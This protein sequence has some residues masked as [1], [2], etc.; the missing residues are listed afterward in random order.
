MDRGVS[1]SRAASGLGRV[2]GRCE[3]ILQMGTPV[4][5]SSPLPSA[6]LLSSFMAE[7]V[8]ERT[9]ATDTDTVAPQVAIAPPP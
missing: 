6:V 9:S 4:Y 7:T 5:K 1:G 2:L 8:M 3:G